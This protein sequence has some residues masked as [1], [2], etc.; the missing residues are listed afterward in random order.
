MKRSKGFTLAELLVIIVIVGLLISLT[1]YTVTRVIKQSRENIKEQN[2]KSLL[3][4]GNTYM[5]QVIDGK[6]VY[7]FNDG[8]FTGYK[9]L[10]NVVEKCGSY[11]TCKTTSADDTNGKYTFE[12]NI[13]L[14]NLKDYIDTSKYADGKCNINAYLTLEKNKNG[15]YEVIG[16]EVKAESK[17]NAKTCVITK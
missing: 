16:L 3:E 17:T 6:E 2:F 12:L 9:F 5:H 14:A 15:Y 13:S 10:T 11:N 8:D 4:A 7:K 1:G